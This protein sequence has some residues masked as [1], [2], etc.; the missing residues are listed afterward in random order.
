MDYRRVISFV[1][2]AGLALMAG[3]GGGGGASGG[4]PP[5][6]TKAAPVVDIQLYGPNLTSAGGP[7]TIAASVTA[8]SGVAGVVAKVTYPNGSVVVVPMSFVSGD[9][10]Q[11][12][13]TAPANTTFVD[14]TYRVIVTATDRDNRTTDSDPPP[15]SFSVPGLLEPPVPPPPPPPRQ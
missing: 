12:S 4:S 2:L 5:A 8:E 7:K 10:Y 11:V 14:A 15:S 6:P 3:C 1:L 13:F 9:L